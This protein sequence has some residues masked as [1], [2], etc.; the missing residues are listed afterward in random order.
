MQRAGAVDD[1]STVNLMNRSV[2]NET[3]NPTVVCLLFLGQM[4]FVR[5]ALAPIDSRTD[6]FDD[7][8]N[9][10]LDEPGSTDR[11]PG[12]RSPP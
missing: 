4:K 10:S 3:K 5:V 7:E 11:P 8:P 2:R 6:R 12:R 9:G 1:R